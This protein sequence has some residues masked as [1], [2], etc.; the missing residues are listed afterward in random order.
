MSLPSP[1]RATYRV[2]LHSGFGFED[3][4]AVVPYV[5]RLGVSHLYTSPI[6]QAAPGS[7]HGYDVVDHSRLN[8]ELGGEAGFER[9]L[10]ALRSAGMGLVV[11]IVPNHMAIGPD[12]AWWWDVLQHGPASR[13]AGHFDVDWAPPGRRLRNV[14]LL[15]VLGDRY[16]RVLEAGDLVLVRDGGTFAIRLADQRFPLDPR[17][18]ETLLADAARRAGSDELRLLARA[19]GELPASIATA[20][21]QLEQR[22][23]DATALA[24]RLAQLA[25]ETVVVEQLDAAVTATNRDRVAIDALL[26]AQNY[27]LAYWRTSSQVLGYRR[28]FDVDTLIGLRVERPEVFEDTHRLILDRVAAGEIQG[29]RIDH[30]DG[31]R[32][33]GAYFDR[34]RAAAPDAWIVA[35]KI[36]ELGEPLRDWPIDGTTGYRFANQATG[37]QVD[38][39]GEEPLTRLYGRLTQADTSWERVAAAARLQALTELLG[40]DLNRLT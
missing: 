16:R 12:N 20:P 13:Y 27:R 21:D 2:Q 22:Q 30:P 40:S 39:R 31:L 15:P 35:E 34:L 7:T 6:L 38:P 32:D 33:P 36:L 14:I 24:E 8:A 19:H 10:E 9:L 3:A 18:L 37:L 23:R 17:S 4:A 29:L 11:D 28:F 25:L 1:P 26:H 5:A